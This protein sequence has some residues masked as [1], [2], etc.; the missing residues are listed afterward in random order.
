MG[1]L[2]KKGDTRVSS[3]LLSGS[4]SGSLRCVVLA[5][6]RLG[7]RRSVHPLHARGLRFVVCVR[8]RRRL[9]AFARALLHI[10]KLT[11]KH[12]LHVLM[13][14]ALAQSSS[15]VPVELYSR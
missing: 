10:N 13:Q 8:Y 3:L 9:I 4:G 2:R 5:V 1:C 14:R 15:T 6:L 11:N 12:T 7:A